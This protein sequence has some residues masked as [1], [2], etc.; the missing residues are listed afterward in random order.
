MG[1]RLNSP[2]V[3]HETVDGE[4]IIVNVVSGV[5]YSLA[6]SGAALWADLLR[7]EEEERLVERIVQAGGESREVAAAEVSRFVAELRA[8]NLVVPAEGAAAPADGGGPGVVPPSEGLSPF[9]PPTLAR[10]ADMEELLLVD[11]I[12]EVQPAG[13]PLK[14][15]GD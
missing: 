3:M 15:G 12:H 8:E 11:P 13:W 2:A 1:Y 6:G 14:H 10:Y 7:G 4:V 9:V 5:Y